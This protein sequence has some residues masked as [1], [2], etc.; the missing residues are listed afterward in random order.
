[1][2]EDKNRHTDQTSPPGGGKPVILLLLSRHFKHHSL[3]ANVGLRL[4]RKCCV[5]QKKTEA[6]YITGLCKKKKKR[7]GF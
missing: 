3:L 2:K 5:F 4:L 7:H 6:I 1:M